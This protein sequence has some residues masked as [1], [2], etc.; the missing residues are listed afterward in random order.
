VLFHA[1]GDEDL[2]VSIHIY[3]T[4]RYF[5]IWGPSYLWTCRLPEWQETTSSHTHRCKYIQAPLML[6][7]PLHL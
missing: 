2:V 3:A 5:E 1:N 4:Q 7:M 6:F